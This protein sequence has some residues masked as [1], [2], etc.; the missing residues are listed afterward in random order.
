MF[1]ELTISTSYLKDFFLNKAV[2]IAGFEMNY[3]YAYEY[4]SIA[5]IIKTLD[6]R[7]YNFHYNLAG[8]CYLEIEKQ[9]EIIIADPNMEAPLVP[10]KK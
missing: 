8:F 5:G 9:K 10:K 1:I 7:Q 3:S 2:E 6:N 4:V